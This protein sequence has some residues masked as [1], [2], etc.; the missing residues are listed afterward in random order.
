MTAVGPTDIWRPIQWLLGEHAGSGSIN[1]RNI[2]GS[3]TVERDGSGSVN[4]RN[5]KGAMRIDD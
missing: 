4:H 3:F 1:V 5:V 2:E